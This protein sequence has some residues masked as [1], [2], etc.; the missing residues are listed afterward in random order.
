MNRLEI[1]FP[2]EAE[3]LKQMNQEFLI[4][5]INALQEIKEERNKKIHDPNKE[6]KGTRKYYV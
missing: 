2:K 4:S 3:I 6:T 5:Q 1:H